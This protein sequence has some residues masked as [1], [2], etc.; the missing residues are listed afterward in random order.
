MPGAV[1]SVV[2]LT[3][4]FQL[5][6]PVNLRSCCESILG[7]RKD[8]GESGLRGQGP[9]PCPSFCQRIGMRTFRTRHWAGQQSESQGENSP[10]Q[11]AEHSLAHSSWAMLH[12]GLY[13]GPCTGIAVPATEGQESYREEVHPNLKGRVGIRQAGTAA[14]IP[15]GGTAGEALAVQKSLVRTRRS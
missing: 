3:V 11:A 8:L 6:F 4:E 14:G 5:C 9:P 15:G 10:A 13:G 12:T 1:R 7:W 2:Q